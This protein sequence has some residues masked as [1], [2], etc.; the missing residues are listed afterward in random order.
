M[1]SDYWCDYLQ[2][3]LHIFDPDRFGEVL[4]GSRSPFDVE[5]THMIELNLPGLSNQGP[6]THMTPGKG[7]GGATYD[8]LGKRLYILGMGIN[9]YSSINRLYVFQVNC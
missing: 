8:A 1:N 6:K 5:P 2:F 9:D 4:K 7:V 3:E